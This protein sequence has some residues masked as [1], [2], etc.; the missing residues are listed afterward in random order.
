MKVII[1]LTSIPSR[2]NKLQGVLGDLALQTSHEIWVN[3]PKSYKRFPEY[4]GSFPDCNFGSKIVINRDCEDLGPGTKFIGPAK[5]LDPDDLIV[6]LDDD[7]FYDY[8]M[9]TNFLKWHKVDT[10]SAWGLSGFNFESYFQGKYPRQHGSFVD[11]L[12]G[13]GAVIVKAGWIQKIAEEFRE[14]Y[15]ITWHDDIIL[16]NLFEKYGIGRRTVFTEE[17]NL[18]NLKQYS[19]GF[20]S[21]ALNS[22]AG[23]GG[24]IENNKK[25]LKAFEDKGKSYFKYKCS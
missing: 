9:V 20:E 11:V 17:C 6:Y 23:P 25:I 21:D 22:I 15:S 18:G 13:Y 7:T 2:F 3:I 10:T 4:D 1:S 12:E 5:F 14:L 16:S 24:H 19:F 8:R